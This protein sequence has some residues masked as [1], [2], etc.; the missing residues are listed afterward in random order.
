M[1]KY[2]YCAVMR[3]ALQVLEEVRIDVAETRAAEQ[4]LRELNDE[5]AGQQFQAGWDRRDSPPMWWEP[6]TAF[7]PASWSFATAADLLMRSADH[8]SAEQSERRNLIMVNPHEG[9]RYPT[10]RTQ[11]LAYQM[12]LPNDQARTHRH[13]PHAG[14]VILDAAGAYTVVNGVGIPM[15]DGDVVLTPG[16]HWH[17]HGHDG[18]KPAFWV[19]FLDIPLVQLLEPMH[20]EPYP[21]N[22]QAPVVM[23]RD[24]PMLFPFEEYKSRLDQAQ[25]DGSGFY[26]RRVPLGD[27]A[28][29]TIGLYAQALDK[30]VETRPMRTTANYQYVVVEGEGTST[31]DGVEISWSRGDAIAAPSWHV[32]SHRSDS[33][34][35][36]IAITDEPLQKYCGYLRMESGD[37]IFSGAS[38]EGFRAG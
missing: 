24:T 38:P 35:I 8:L 31:I 9:N 23:T 27:P 1:G 17:G 3:A 12:V 20:F 28:L 14:R 6:R 32:H 7:K 25:P 4:N 2:V 26:G 30:G 13:S 15:H 5:I 16:M 18:D 34:A 36:L 10:V 21:D 29:P 19:D 22:W 37:E 11:V 33:D